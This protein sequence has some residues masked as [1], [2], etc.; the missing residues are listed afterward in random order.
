MCLCTNPPNTGLFLC[1]YP[2]LVHL[3]LLLQYFCLT[4]RASK[5]PQCMSYLHSIIFLRPVYIDYLLFSPRI[6]KFSRKGLL[7][8]YLLFVLFTSMLHSHYPKTSRWH[9]KITL[10]RGDLQN[11]SSVQSLSLSS[12]A[13]MNHGTPGPPCPT[14]SSRFMPLVHRVNAIICILLCVPFLSTPNPPSIS[15]LQLV[16]ALAQVAKVLGFPSFGI[17]PLKN[18]QGDLCFRMDWLDHPS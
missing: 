9:S 11:N 1:R 5:V 8:L 18:T 14:P 6:N 15:P 3:L 17:T 2:I 12:F 13:F 10:V 7:F 4:F 16:M